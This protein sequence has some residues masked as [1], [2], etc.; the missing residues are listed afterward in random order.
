MTSNLGSNFLLEGIRS[1]AGNEEK[2]RET[3]M[4]ELRRSFKPEFLN[5]VDEIVMFKPLQKKE[6]VKIIDLSLDDIRRRLE[7]RHITLDVTDAARNFIADTAY[8]P[9]YGARPV[10]RFLQKE[11][12]T[13]LGKL[14]IKGEVSEGS[15]VMVD[16]GDNSLIIS[17]NDLM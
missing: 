7:D 15:K 10:K 11:L 9:E 16:A 8:T 17:K 5:R 3:V 2:L 14:I 13:E 1:G 4:A 12:E 6:I